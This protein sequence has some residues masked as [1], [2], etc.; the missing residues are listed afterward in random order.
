MLWDDLLTD[1]D[2]D[3]IRLGG[4][5][6]PRGL[7]VKPAVLVV[8]AQYNYLGEDAPLQQS[9][10]KWPSSSGE[11]AWAALRKGLPVLATARQTGVPVI[12]TRQVQKQTLNFDGFQRKANRDR[13]MYMEGHKG[14]AI[15]AECEVQPDE[16]VIDKAFA[17]AFFGTPLAS[18]VVGMGVDTLLVMGGTTG[19]CV[20]MTAVD[21]ISHNFHVA[22]IQDALF[23][24]IEASHKV[25][26]LD[27][28]MKYGDL[29]ASHEAVQYLKS[30]AEG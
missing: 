10:Q 7:G 8:D 6:M 14:T 17:S 11:R 15:V 4:Y 9:I 2:K 18:Y 19:G 1:T 30:R 3:V 26:L 27:F 16:L 21:A 20:R 25:A 5:G 12:F 13:G 24:R 29:I 23:D 22:L 28:W